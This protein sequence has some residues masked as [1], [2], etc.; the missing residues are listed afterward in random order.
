V[1]D[2]T[3]NDGKKRLAAGKPSR[4]VLREFTLRTPECAGGSGK[5]TT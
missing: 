1:G 4:Y 2:R 5:V 3:Q